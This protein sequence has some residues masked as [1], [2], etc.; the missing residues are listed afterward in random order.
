MSFAAV[1]APAPEDTCF[2]VLE[3]TPAPDAQARRDAW[4]R[5]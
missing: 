2:L 5:G 1:L 4:L 3:A